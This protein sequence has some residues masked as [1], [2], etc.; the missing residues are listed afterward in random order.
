MLSQVLC[1]ARKDGIL[2]CD[3]LRR[4]MAMVMGGNL[5]IWVCL[6]MLCTPKPNGFADHSPYEKWLFHWE[7]TLFS[8]KPISPA[9]M[10]EE[11]CKDVQQNQ[12]C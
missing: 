10:V 4:A 5:N 9:N 3:K 7:Y 1:E 12:T 6:K 8:D 11:D 2:F